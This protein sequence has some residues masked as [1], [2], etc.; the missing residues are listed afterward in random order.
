MR[1]KK[2][3]KKMQLKNS[4]KRLLDLFCRFIDIMR[5]LKQKKNFSLRGLTQAISKR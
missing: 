5:D 3:L 4:G 2:K 1:R